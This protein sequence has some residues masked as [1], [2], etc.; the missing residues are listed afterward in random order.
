MKRKE[1]LAQQS[2]GLDDKAANASQDSSQESPPFAKILVVDDE[3][4]NLRLVENH[5][6]GMNYE[7][8]CYQ[9]GN[10]ALESLNQDDPDLILLDL[11]M[12]GVDGYEV[13]KVIRSNYLQ[14]QLPIIVITANQQEHVTR[15]S[16]QLGANDYL[17][18]P[19]SAEELR[20]RINSQLRI[21]KQQI[22]QEEMEMLQEREKK[23][24]AERLRVNR[25]LDDLNISLAMVD[26]QGMTLQINKEF[27]RLF[28]FSQSQ[29]QGKQMK[30][31]L[32][33]EEFEF[34]DKHSEISLRDVSGKRKK[35][36]VRSNRVELQEQ[37]EYIIIMIPVET[38]EQE[39]EPVL[40]RFSKVHGDS[41]STEEIDQNELLRQKLCNLL[42]LSVKYYEYAT[43]N[44]YTSLAL[45]SGLWH[46]TLN[47]TTYRAY[48][49]E[50]YMNPERIPGKFKWGVVIKTADWVLKNCEEYKELKNKIL[51]EKTEIE[52]ILL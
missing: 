29:A 50:R 46:A 14:S 40:T 12:P 17:I 16:I 48:M 51:K 4:L 23:E 34:K 24:R 30:E 19:Y 1:S 36:S 8:L 28:G 39:T 42:N 47:G 6:G 7:L 21:S 3:P 15:K 20:V 2:S 45:D 18:K 35:M 25:I 22:M 41:E 5:L 52:D 11:M 31:L 43:G 27:Q 13:I 49:M 26:A 10:Q 9:D 37:D 38:G 32:G 44:N 33:L